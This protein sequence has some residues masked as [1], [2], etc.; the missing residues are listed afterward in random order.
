M[1]FT[2]ELSVE[3]KR[4]ALL[5]TRKVRKQVLKKAFNR[6]MKRFGILSKIGRACCGQRSIYEC[7]DVFTDPVKDCREDQGKIMT[8]ILIE[9]GHE[10]NR[11]AGDEAYF[12]AMVPL[13]SEISATPLSLLHSRIV[14]SATEAL[15][16]GSRLFGWDILKSLLSLGKIINAIR[17][18][19]IYV[20]GAGQIL[21]DDTHILAPPYRL[22]RPFLAFHFW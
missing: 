7:D 12:A 21:R 1:Y 19:D 5:Y 17:K 8:R 22:Y 3:E 9:S 16:S 2:P 11:N 18:C 6:K 20:W 4:R 14:L 10:R 15:Y 13:V